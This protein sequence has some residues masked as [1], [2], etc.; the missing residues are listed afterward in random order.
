MA[1]KKTANYKCEHCGKIS[2]KNIKQAEKSNHHFCSMK[3]R[4][5]SKPI[6][7]VKCI[8]LNCGKKFE[9]IYARWI[10]VKKHFCCRS[11]HTAWRNENTV[12][13]DYHCDFCNKLFQIYP[14]RL[15]DN[16][17]HFC[18]MECSAKWISKYQIRENC[19]HW[20]GGRHKS[21]DGYIYINISDKGRRR[22]E[23]RLIMEKHLGR[24][25]SKKEEIHHINGIRD[26]NRLENLCVVDVSKHEKHTLIKQCKKRILELESIVKGIY[27]CPN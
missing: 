27:A 14:H 6:K 16:K 7:K 15:K 8:C 1:K 19:V 21:T 3:C 4:N 26:D 10:G 20:R 22:M 5:E 24:K 11:C 25:L 9:K 18:N 2:I 12:K 13:T 23:H 17:N